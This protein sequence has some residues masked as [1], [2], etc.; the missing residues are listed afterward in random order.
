MSLL[1]DAKAGAEERDFVWLEICRVKHKIL[2]ELANAGFNPRMEQEFS[3][4]ESVSVNSSEDDVR[5]SSEDR[6]LL[7]YAVARYEDSSLNQDVKQACMAA[8]VLLHAKRTFL[9]GA[10]SYELISSLL[11]CVSVYPHEYDMELLR[12]RILRPQLKGFS[13][14][15]DDSHERAIKRYAC[16]QVWAE[17]IWAKP[18][19]GHLS[20]SAVAR[21]I[22]TS[23]RFKQKGFTQKAA[24]IAEKIRDSR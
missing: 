1:K 9:S 19:K 20:R 12:K 5:G 24:T 3:S 18:G 4:G 7:Q 17:E 8:I 15:S 23:S 13:R 16:W 2:E 11:L 14:S 22:E 6:E 21:I 10:I